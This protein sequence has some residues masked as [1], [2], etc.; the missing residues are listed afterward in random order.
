MKRIKSGNWKQ[1]SEVEKG[2][3]Q[4]EALT[5][6]IGIIS[7]GVVPFIPPK[8]QHLA[9]AKA[10]ETHPGKIATEASVRMIA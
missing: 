2:L 6:N 3:E 5:K 10:N 7:R 4:K 8:L 1:C 9:L